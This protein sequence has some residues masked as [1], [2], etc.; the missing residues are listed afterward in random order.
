MVKKYSVF[1]YTFFLYL[2]TPFDKICDTPYL[3]EYIVELTNFQYLT[4]LDPAAHT[5]VFAEFASF[6]IS[7]Q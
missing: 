2:A 7:I 1:N 6:G 4:F 3:I 5:S